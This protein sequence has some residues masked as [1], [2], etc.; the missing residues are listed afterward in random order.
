[1]HRHTTRLARA[2]GTCAVAL[3]AAALASCGDGRVA[4]Y[5]AHGK[6]LDEKGKPAAGAVVTFHPV[7]PPG[8]GV[9]AVSGT[10]GADGTY[11]LTTYET[12]DGAPAGE[13]VV[14][15]CWYKPKKT[16]FDPPPPDLLC[17]KY[18]DRQASKFRFKV[19]PKPD[20]ELPA[21]TVTVPK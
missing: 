20:N 19:E 4:V 1:M 12:G 9:E 7:A 16:P 3:V 2:A 18:A 10:V 15:V 6:V 13:Y 17:G 21:I 5:P 8:G 11:R 14:T